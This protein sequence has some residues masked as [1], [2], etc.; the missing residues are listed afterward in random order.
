MVN[1]TATVFMVNIVPFG[2]ETGLTPEETVL[3]ISFFAG[4][5]LLGTPIFGWVV[6]KLHGAASLLLTAALQAVFWFGLLMVPDNMLL[7]LAALLGICAVPINVLHQAVL[8]ELLEPSSISRGLGISY[9]IKLPFVF[10]F[11]P[12][13]A[14]LFE[15]SGSYDLP[16][17]MTGA[18][19][20]VASILFLLALF[21]KLPRHDMPNASSPGR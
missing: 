2:R 1:A 6:D 12:V 5:G 7:L 8:S 10:S 9:A 11:A 15:G 16:F 13:A 4:A 20:G 17:M 18:M 14:L 3:L 19:L 21:V